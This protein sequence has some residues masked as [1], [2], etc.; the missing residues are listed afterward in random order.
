MIRVVHVS[1]GLDIGGQERMLAEFARHA[2]RARFDLLFISLTNRGRLA[3]TIEDLG[4]PVIALEQ[5]L[6]IQPRLI[7][8]MREVFRAKAC[9]VVHTHDDR[10][11]LY[12]SFAVKL[13]RVRRYVHTQHHGLLPQMTPRQRK[14]AAW[15]GRLADAFVCVSHDAARTMEATGL[16]SGRI[17]VLHNGIDLE[18][19]TYQEPCDRGPAVT[20]ARLSPE[21][22]IANLLRAAALIVPS[23]PDFGLQIAGDGPQRGE[24]TKLARSLGLENHVRFLGE[25]SDVPALLKQARLFVLPSQTE[26]ISLTILEAM[27]CGLPVVATHVGGTPEVVEQGATGLLVPPRDPEALARALLRL[28]CNPVEGRDMGRAGRLR[29]EASFDIR[30]MVAGYEKLYEEAIPCLTRSRRRGSGQ[31]SSTATC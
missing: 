30:T 19:Y 16:P 26:G 8:S 13:A 9:D 31:A 29:V 11:L 20:V 15:A 24:L 23:A 17:S 12:G 14:L 4:W 2:D 1:L 7:W 27:A 6:G 5:P 18:K 10:P 21:K 25:V 22:D 3:H 28:W